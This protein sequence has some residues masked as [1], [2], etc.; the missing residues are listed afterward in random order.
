MSRPQGATPPVGPR[1]SPG[2]VAPHS[3][4][5]RAPIL[6]LWQ[7]A[8]PRDSRIGS[9]QQQ[10]NERP[11]AASLHAGAHPAARRTAPQMQ[12]IRL[13]SICTDNMTGPGRVRVVACDLDARS[14]RRQT[15]AFLRKAPRSESRRSRARLTRQRCVVGHTHTLTHIAVCALWLQHVCVVCARVFHASSVMIVTEWRGSPPSFAGQSKWDGAQS[16]S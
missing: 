8:R 2:R 9:P 3:R 12:I 1:T 14:E 15:S 16:S 4:S 10:H 5:P 6:D 7:V 11:V 13:R